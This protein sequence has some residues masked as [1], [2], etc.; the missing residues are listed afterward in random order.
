MYHSI[1]TDFIQ[2]P[3]K[4]ILIE[5][6]NASRAIGNGI[7]TQP[8]YTYIMPSLFLKMTGAQEQKL[9]CI[10]WEI[11]THDYDYR[12]RLLGNEDK[13]GEYSNYDAKNKI[14]TH[15]FKQ[16]KDCREILNNEKVNLINRV[17][18]DIKDIFSRSNFCTWLQKDFQNFNKGIKTKFSEKQILAEDKKSG[19]KLFEN[20]LQKDYEEIVYKERN[21][22]AHNTTSYQRDVPDLDALASEEYLWH[23]YFY[24]Y[25]I[26]VLIDEIFML[27]YNKYIEL[28]KEKHIM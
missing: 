6:V 15:L 18:G 27:L 10:C 14:L 9:K 11:A 17:I 13:L 24:R 19:V 7:E 22:C 5:G 21:R 12:R 16:I 20:V 2:T 8:L 25:A 28:I 3:I 4:E 26:L 23:N 1:H